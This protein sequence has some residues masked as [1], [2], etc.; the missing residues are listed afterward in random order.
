MDRFCLLGLAQSC[1]DLFLVGIGL[2]CEEAWFNSVE[3]GLRLDCR[4]IDH[5]SICQ[6]LIQILISLSSGAE[7]VTLQGIFTV[8]IRVN[9]TYQVCLLGQI[10]DHFHVE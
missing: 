4:Q 7:Q 8:D 9:V 3:D 2:H 5:I 10:P 6:C 1:K